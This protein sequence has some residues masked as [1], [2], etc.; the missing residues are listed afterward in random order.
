M[1]VFVISMLLL[2]VT[3]WN[4]LLKSVESNQ[5]GWLFIWLC[6]AILSGIMMLVITYNLYNEKKLKSY[7]AEVKESERKG[8]FSESEVIKE[9][10]NDIKETKDINVKEA[11]EE[12]VP[13]IKGIK[14]VESFADRLLKSLASKFQMVQGLCYQESKGNFRTIAKFAFTGEKD[15]ESF[16]LGVTLG[17]QAAA[18]Q[19][20]ML[21]SNIPESYF[22]IES[23]LGK[24]YP[25]HLVFVPVIYKKKTI[26]LIEMAYF[27][28]LDEQT[29]SVFREL[30]GYLGERFVKIMK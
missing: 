15:P 22:K 8:I 19:E 10:V 30:T 5:H 11:I 21:V 3:I 14:T 26:A 25:K 28:S 7:I 27:I 4:H 29:L 1:I 16:K 9:N 6:L 20:M 18:N 2:A 12:F 13:D 24:S 17:G 23:G